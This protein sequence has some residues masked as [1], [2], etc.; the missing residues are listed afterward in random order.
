[1]PSNS[2][3]QLRVLQM[4]QPA[5]CKIMPAGLACEDNDL[6][7]GQHKGVGRL[8]IDNC[9]PQQLQRLLCAAH[10]MQRAG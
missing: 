9:V 3:G 10:R 2:S 5:S 4:G 8:V 1:M 6:A 7:T